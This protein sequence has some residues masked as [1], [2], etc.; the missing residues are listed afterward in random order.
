MVAV[1]VFVGYHIDAEN[2]ARQR[3]GTESERGRRFAEL[4]VEVDEDERSRVSR[5]LHDEPLQLVAHLARSLERLERMPQTPE[6]LAKDLTGARQHALE[7][8]S[9]LRTIAKG[10]RPPALEQLGLAAALRGLLAEAAE[11]A[12]IRTSLQVTGT[13]TRLPPKIELA[14]FRIAQEAVNKRHPPRRGH[15]AGDFARVQP[16]RPAAAVADDGQGFEP[17]TQQ[18]SRGQ[19]TWGCAG[20]E[21]GLPPAYPPPSTLLR[22]AAA[23]I[24][25]VPR[26]VEVRC[27][28]AARRLARIFLVSG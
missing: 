26:V 8:A 13:E 7:I 20:W 28:A 22:S 19:A 15:A 21:S 24:T 16:K 3:A 1:A 5:E 4:L 12:N 14:A 23:R 17:A 6:T 25:A 2:V 11:A 18:A 10:L 9:R 27:R